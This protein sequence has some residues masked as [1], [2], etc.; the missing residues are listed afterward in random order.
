MAY[1]A[2]LQPVSLEVEFE[3]W[4]Y[5][6]SEYVLL[7]QPVPLF[8]SDQS[9]RSVA[10]FLTTYELCYTDHGTTCGLTGQIKEQDLHRLL[11]ASFDWIAMS[12]S[13]RVNSKR[14]MTGRLEL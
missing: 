5:I 12:M 14:F 13:D 1:H 6:L 10:F 3:L 4:A 2:H 8:R 9:N 11:H 7:D